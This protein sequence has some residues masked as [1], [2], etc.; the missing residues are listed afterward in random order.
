MLGAYQCMA[1][2]TAPG[3]KIQGSAAV[4]GPY[5]DTRSGGKLTEVPRKV[6][7]EHPATLVAAIVDPILIPI[8]ELHV[9]A[10]L[11]KVAST[12]N[13]R[14]DGILAKREALVK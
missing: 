14:P 12:R 8:G 4:E 2:G 13:G 5:D 6:E 3:G 1:R 10:L 9:H 11:R 7:D